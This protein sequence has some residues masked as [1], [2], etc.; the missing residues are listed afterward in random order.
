MSAQAAEKN[1]KSAPRI[2]AGKIFYSF[3]LLKDF[4]ESAGKLNTVKERKQTRPNTVNAKV[5]K[6]LNLL[7]LKECARKYISD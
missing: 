4:L 5:V 2:C 1:K 3:L 7:R 6:K